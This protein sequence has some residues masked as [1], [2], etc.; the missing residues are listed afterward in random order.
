MLISGEEKSATDLV[1]E[2]RVNALKL[3]WFSLSQ[4]VGFFTRFTDFAVN[5][6]ML[7][8]IHCYNVLE[9]FNDK[10]ARKWNYPK[11][12]NAHV[13]NMLNMYSKRNSLKR[14]I[15]KTIFSPPSQTK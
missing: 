13:F 6:L 10:E 12:N 7:T 2:V 14:A 9:K 11:N 8:Q 5:N 3:V 4:H 15:E 1:N